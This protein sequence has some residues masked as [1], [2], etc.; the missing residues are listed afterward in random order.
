[1]P[2]ACSGGS[3]FSPRGDCVYCLCTQPDMKC[4]PACLTPCSCYS[5]ALLSHF[6]F[7]AEY[8]EHN[9]FFFSSQ[10]GGSGKEAKDLS[11]AAKRQS[12]A[13][14]TCACHTAPSP[15]SGFHACGM[16]VTCSSQRQRLPD[17]GGSHLW[18]QEMSLHSSHGPHRRFSA[19]YASGG[20]DEEKEGRPAP[21]HHTAEAKAW[22]A[23]VWFMLCVHLTR[24]PCLF[25]DGI[26]T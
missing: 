19:P 2:L 11:R 14:E 8:L 6:V 25:L 26:N 15:C 10:S 16:G 9:L 22:A 3:A 1:M 12:S 23:L 4:A 21:P 13:S 17:P 5:L 24:P 7:V 20:C 18:K